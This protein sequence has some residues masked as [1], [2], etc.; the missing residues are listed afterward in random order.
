MTPSDAGDGGGNGNGVALALGE[1]AGAVNGAWRRS[2]LGGRRR[3]CAAT[4]ATAAA[5]AHT[6]GR[7]LGLWL[8]LA[9]WMAPLRT[10][11]AALELCGDNSDGGDGGGA[12][13]GCGTAL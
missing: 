9:R 13:A 10:R 7:A 1:G 6:P 2:A 3:S 12:R 8:A 5:S 4:T 11:G